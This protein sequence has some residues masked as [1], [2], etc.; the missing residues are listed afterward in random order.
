MARDITVSEDTPN[1]GVLA[2]KVAERPKTHQNKYGQEY[3]P[4]TPGSPAY[5]K[6]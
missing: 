5:V 4:P 3:E 2:L 6:P 1:L